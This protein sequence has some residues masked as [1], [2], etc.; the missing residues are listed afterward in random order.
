MY[1]ELI[2]DILVDVPI[3]HKNNSLDEAEVDKL[4]QMNTMILR[5]F[6]L[7]LI[8]LGVTGNAVTMLV[9]RRMATKENFLTLLLAALCGFN[10]L[11]LILGLIDDV[12]YAW[13]DIALYSVSHSLCN[14][15]AV[16]NLVLLTIT[17]WLVVVITG[18]RVAFLTNKSKTM[19]SVRNQILLIDSVCIGSIFAQTV[20]GYFGNR[21]FYDSNTTEAC[22]VPYDSPWAH[23]QFYVSSLIPFI[24]LIL[25]NVYLI[26]LYMKKDSGLIESIGTTKVRHQMCMFVLVSMLQ[27][28]LTIIPVALLYLN[29]EMFFDMN[30]RLG[31]AKA[32]LGYNITVIMLYS[33]NATNYLVYTAFGRRFRQQFRKL[34]RPYFKRWFPTLGQEESYMDSDCGSRESRFS[35]ATVSHSHTMEMYNRPMTIPH[36]S[37]TTVKYSGVESSESSSFRNVKPES[38]GTTRNIS[39]GEERKVDSDVTLG[40]R[41]A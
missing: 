24:V 12:I 41:V 14:I 11:A 37:D 15:F 3:P 4:H 13:A 19:S 36:I 7:V 10:I 31:Q 28:V 25:L 17:C 40:A 21:S 1:T 30:S 29:I 2:E 20:V 18:C 32:V 26:Y 23:I 39:L 35:Q 8:V 33:N 27:Y 6:P 16:L 22:Y 9:L 5:I 34:L 38:S